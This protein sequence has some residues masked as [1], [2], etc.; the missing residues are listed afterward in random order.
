MSEEKTYRKNVGAILLAAGKSSRLGTPKQ[1]LLYKGETLLQYILNSAIASNAHPV[2]VVLG[3]HAD[4]I[5]QKINSN[6]VTVIVNDTW[7]EGMAS[8]I[9]V[10]IKT[11]LQVNPSAEG[12]VLMVCDQPY[13]T[14]SLLNDLIEAHQKTGKPIITC[15]Y[16]N[17]FGPPTL[18]H[19]SIFQELLQLKGDVGARNILRNHADKVEAIL[20]P[21]GNEDIDTKAD[22]EKLSKDIRET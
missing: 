2:I 18:F 4:I 1:L 7:Q 19:Q 13:I 14:S 12:A 10:G 6:T 16:A 11:L 20:F 15:S 3:A 21:H 22:Y 8:S 17:T 9:R 5:E